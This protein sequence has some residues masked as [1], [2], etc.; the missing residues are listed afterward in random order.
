MTR[1]GKKHVIG[2]H[3]FQGCVIQWIDNISQI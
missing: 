3:K 2:L 1:P